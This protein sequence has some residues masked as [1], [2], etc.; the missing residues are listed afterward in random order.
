MAR[1]LFLYSSNRYGGIVRNL[2]HIVQHLDPKEFQLSVVSLRGPADQNNQL[3]LG[4]REDVVFREISDHSKIDF[5][6]LRELANTVRQKEITVLSCHGYK[7]DVYGVL[8][9]YWYRLPVRLVTIA[10]GW[11]TPG[12]R[13]SLYYFLDKCAMRF[14]DK[15]ILVSETQRRD[16]RRFGVGSEKVELIHNAIDPNGMQPTLDRCSAR[17][18]FSLST[19]QRVLGFAGRLSP[20]KGLDVS[21]RAVQLL[22]AEYPDIALLI[23][24]T[25]PQQEELE[26]LATSLS[27]RDAVQFLGFRKDVANV[28]QAIDVYISSARKEGL[29]NNLLEAQ[30]MSIPCI[31]SDIPGNNDIVQ[32][33]ENGILVPVDSPNHLAEAVKQL[34]DDTERK[35]RFVQRGNALLQEKFSLQ[36]RIAK[37]E[38]VYRSFSTTT[39]AQ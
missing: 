23:C 39:H 33:G 34:L 36:T 18:E 15:V 6:A 21:I 1:I 28:Y 8:L 25:G 9:R 30:A 7:A 3:D 17:A 19:E 24:G 35:T 20:E 29:P 37:L 14:F 22:R 16:V 12:F 13:M 27:I 26:Q 11:V 31:V 2:S 38:S 5:K 4:D 10:H 32:N